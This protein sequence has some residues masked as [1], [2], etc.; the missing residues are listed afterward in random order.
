VRKGAEGG[1][2]K[3]GR[4]AKGRAYRIENHLSVR[5]QIEFAMRIKFLSNPKK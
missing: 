3:G 1:K 5:A 2:E 4:R